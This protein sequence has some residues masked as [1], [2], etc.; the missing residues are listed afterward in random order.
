MNDIYKIKARKYKL[1]YLKLK[2]KY[3]SEGGSY[4]FYRTA[5][6]VT[7][8]IP[9][10]APLSPLFSLRIP[11]ILPQEQRTQEAH[12]RQLAQQA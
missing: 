10:L 8:I 11:D 1:K 6:T 12:L 5:A 2:Q 7:N 4:D 9:G 3:I